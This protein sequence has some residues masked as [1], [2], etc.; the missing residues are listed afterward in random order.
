M[1]DRH[2]LFVG[3]FVH[4]G[5]FAELSV[6]PSDGLGRPKLRHPLNLDELSRL[7]A[8]VCPDEA[9]RETWPV[10]FEDGLLVVEALTDDPAVS[11]FLRKLLADFDCELVEGTL[12]V[13]NPRVWGLGP[14]P[15]RGA[16]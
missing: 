3:R 16:G 11:T 2:I 5:Y 8:R 7:A 13:V 15:T 6:R 14:E 1:T 10:F 9:R 4:D 12:R